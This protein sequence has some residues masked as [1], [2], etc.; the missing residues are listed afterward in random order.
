MKCYIKDKRTFKTKYHA[1]AVNWSI[2]LES[3][4]DEVSTFEILGKKEVLYEGDYL[5]AG[6]FAGV[7]KSVEQAGEYLMI[8]CDDIITIFN[9]PL[10]PTE[11]SPMIGGFE[12]FLK[13]RI[14]HEYLNISDQV[15]KLPFIKVIASTITHGATM[16]DIEDDLWNIK[17]YVAKLRR[18]NGI[19]LSFEIQNNTELVIRIFHKEKQSHNVFLNMSCY[20]LM[21]E[22]YANNYVGKVTTKI[23]DTENSYDWYLLSDGTI[24]KTYSLESRVDGVW[25][26]LIVENLVDAEEKAHEIFAQ[27]SKSHLIEFATENKFNFY[28]NLKIRTKEGRVLQSYI[29]AVRIEKGRNKVIYKTGELRVL[30]HEKLNQKFGGS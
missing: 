30:L 19:F 27:N 29:S 22:T 25:E 2:T 17:S 9:R 18:L 13:R 1:D 20:E 8:T 5:F 6:N 12:A 28:D 15:Y 23:K 26:K 7:I 24:T 3:I 14:E 21:E 16:P 4:Y 11:D 10:F